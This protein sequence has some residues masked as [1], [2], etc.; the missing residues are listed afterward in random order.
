MHMKMTRKS[1]AVAIR[2]A[3]LRNH[4]N[5]TQVYEKMDKDISP[6]THECVKKYISRLQFDHMI[7]DKYD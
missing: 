2:E 7:D 3:I 5:D 4:L 1:C 6:L